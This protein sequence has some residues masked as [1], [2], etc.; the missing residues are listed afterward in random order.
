MKYTYPTVTEI[1][2]FYTNSEGYLITPEALKYGKGYS[3]VEVQAPY[4]YIL[5]SSPMYF[6]IS[7]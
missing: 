4:G 6:N 3:V 5:D 1:D 2:I 7:V